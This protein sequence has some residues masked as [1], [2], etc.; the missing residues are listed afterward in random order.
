MSSGVGTPAGAAAG[1]A[2]L[3]HTGA[4]RRRGPQRGPAGGP[5]QGSEL[6]GMIG[7]SGVLGAKEAPLT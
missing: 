1:P 3:P 2:F 7:I 5:A 6:R 4:A